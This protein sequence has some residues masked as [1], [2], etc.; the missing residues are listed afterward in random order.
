MTSQRLTTLVVGYEDV[1][2]ALADFHDRRRSVR[3]MTWATTRLQWFAIVHRGH[4]L[5]TTTHED[6]GFGRTSS[7]CRLGGRRR[8]C[9]LSSCWEKAKHST[10][11]QAS[12]RWS[13]ASLTESTPSEHLDMR[14]VGRSGRRQRRKPHRYRR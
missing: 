10:R 1:E 12:A 4:E 6:A 9:D 13:E 8:G 11:S 7:R 2:V 14:E 5:V 3:R